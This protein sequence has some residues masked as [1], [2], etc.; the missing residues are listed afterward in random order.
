MIEKILASGGARTH[1]PS[2]SW[3]ALNPLSYR[4][5]LEEEETAQMLEV[6]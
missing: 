3:P 1:K 2:I 4:G 6:L 5:S